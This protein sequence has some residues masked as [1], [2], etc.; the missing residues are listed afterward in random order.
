MKMMMM[1]MS[2]IGKIGVPVGKLSKV[3]HKECQ[4]D[5]QGFWSIRCPKSLDTLEVALDICDLGARI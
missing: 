5:Q 2:R 4:N 3:P 1:E